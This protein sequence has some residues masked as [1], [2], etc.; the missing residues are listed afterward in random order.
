[1]Y[2]LPWEG[3]L[4]VG[5]VFVASSSNEANVARV[6]MWYGL[7]Y[8]LHHSSVWLF[9]IFFTVVFCNRNH[10]FSRLSLNLVKN[11]SSAAR[12]S[13]FRRLLRSQI[14]CIVATTFGLYLLVTEY[15]SWPS[16]LLTHWSPFCVP[17][18]E[19]ALAHWL[20]SFYED[21]KSNDE[22]IAHM[23][24]MPG[25]NRERVFKNYYGGLIYHHFFTALAYTWSLWTHN[26]AGLC[27]FGLLFEAPVII[28]NV[29]ELIAAFDKE[30]QFPFQKC[31]RFAFKLYGNILFGL[32]H[33]CRTLF[34]FLYPLSLVIWRRQLYALPWGSHLMYHLLGLLF[35][36]VNF[37]LYGTFFMR[38]LLEDG[39]KAGLVDERSFWRHFRVKEKYLK[40]PEEDDSPDLEKQSS[41]DVDR[42]TTVDGVAPIQSIGHVERSDEYV[43]P[44]VSAKAQAS[45]NHTLSQGTKSVKATKAADNQSLSTA[46][47][48]NAQ[49]RLISAQ[50]LALHIEPSSLW[51]AVN[52]FVYDVTSF[53]NKHP[54]GMDSLLK[55]AGKDASKQF[56]EVGH[57]Q[58]ARRSMEKY[59][60]GRLELS[61]DS[62]SESLKQSLESTNGEKSV[63]KRDV[64]RGAV[65][66]KVTGK[67][68]HPILDTEYEGPWY[69]EE[70]PYDSFKTYTQGRELYFPAT[71]IFFASIVFLTGGNRVLYGILG[72]SS[73]A[74]SSDNST[75]ITSK[76]VNTNAE[77]DAVVEFAKIAQVASSHGML[78]C[79][80]I[81]IFYSLQFCY[82]SLFRSSNLPATGSTYTT[83]TFSIMDLFK[84]WKYVNVL[85]VTK[86]FSTCILLEMLLLSLPTYKLALTSMRISL[87]L[88]YGIE[89]ALRKQTLNNTFVISLLASSAVDLWGLSTVLF[90]SHA[91]IAVTV[92]LTTVLASMSRLI[93]MRTV[94]DTPT[95]IPV[96]AIAFFLL[97]HLRSWFIELNDGQDVLQSLYATTSGAT[98]SIPSADISVS[99]FDWLDTLPS[100][101][102]LGFSAFVA[103]Y[104]MWPA[105]YSQFIALAEFSNVQYASQFLLVVSGML[106]WTLAGSVGPARWWAFVLAVYGLVRI[107]Y[108]C[109]MTLETAGASAPRHLFRS[110]Q[111]EDA[112]RT[113]LAVQI[114]GFI[115]KPLIRI[116][117]LLLPLKYQYYLYPTPVFDFGDKVDYGVAF[118]VNG[119][120]QQQP[121]VFQHN[122]G[123]FGHEDYDH[124]RT[125]TATREM[126]WELINDPDAGKKGFV[127]DTVAIFPLSA[128]GA[129]PVA[130]GVDP[131][132]YLNSILDP[133]ADIEGREAT[134]K[135]REINLSAWASE[136]AAYDWYK[137]SPAHKKIV[138]E[139]HSGE[140]REFSAMLA[141]LVAPPNRPIKWQTRCRGCHKMTG[142]DPGNN[143]CP[144]CGA[145]ERF[146][147][148]YL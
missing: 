75:S 83:S 64:E 4:L 92:L 3:F 85:V 112:V 135:H 90:K 87:L 15:Y 88:S 76:V 17:A 47:L 148:P 30:I 5:L 51:I 24:M 13:N 137:N 28:I 19:M 60:I 65:L 98:S 43:K 119:D 36:G 25:E 131:L 93:C 145:V 22:V 78:L 11:G 70:G 16:S 86:V 123:H 125:G 107:S 94:R 10:W 46:N 6:A 63:S 143:T 113:L 56:L 122:V 115:V 96:A 129:R 44:A 66:S 117:N 33:L 99:M 37:I 104:L 55:V 144:H 111:I 91:S 103:V 102:F 35:C 77:S 127:A 105:L 2:Y 32:F 142:N 34:C 79:V 72:S 61:S 116:L 26:L 106:L 132:E 108:E 20:F 146:P 121:V 58:G 31:S 45:H 41:H 114:A 69:T 7:W 74:S 38:Y 138:K 39:V 128:G 40:N 71:V 49:S 120:P 18:F 139:Y 67:E 126:I 110:K 50:E 8:A 133:A 73:S 141:T 95:L 109:G 130:P 54:G 23:T 147:L 118:Q 27:V 84:V 100:H 12:L 82:Q 59:K 29:R 124:I 48:D 68:R 57:S 136:K 52:G 21:Y 9:N 80:A 1:M 140:L 14:Y 81:G 62:A 53:L 42:S 89:T 97:W 134:Y 101:P